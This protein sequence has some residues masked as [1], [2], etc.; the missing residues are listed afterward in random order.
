MNSKDLPS[1]SDAA[2]TDVDIK[3]TVKPSGHVAAPLEVVLTPNE[4][5]VPEGVTGPATPAAA[6]SLKQIHVEEPII[7][8]V[9]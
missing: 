7:S 4:P 6:P 5:P 9:R 2:P 8:K 1:K 3:A